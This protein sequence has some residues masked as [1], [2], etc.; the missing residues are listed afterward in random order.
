M[1]KYK[2]IALALKERIVEENIRKVLNYL[3]KKV[4]LESLKQAVLLSAK[5]YNSL[6]MK[7]CYIRDV[8][9]VLLYEAISD[10]TMRMS[11]K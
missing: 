5:L 8:D 1:P 11:L 7:V 10:R 4:W 3:S 2:E 9:L 6:L